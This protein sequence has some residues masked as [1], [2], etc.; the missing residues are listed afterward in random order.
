MSENKWRFCIQILFSIMVIFVQKTFCMVGRGKLVLR[1]SSF[2]APF[3]FWD[4]AYTLHFV[5]L[6]EREN[7][8]NSFPRVGIDPTTD[9]H[10]LIMKISQCVNEER[11]IFFF[12]KMP[13][14]K[15]R[16]S[17]F[18]LRLGNWEPSVKTLRSH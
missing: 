11:R 3:S 10:T 18:Y 8:I 2:H 1:H 5:L 4:I 13:L 17:H 16:S 12:N 7:E 14:C 9:I 6:P 15:G